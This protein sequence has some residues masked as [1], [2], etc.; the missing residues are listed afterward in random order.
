MFQ[1]LLNLLLMHS[2]MIRKNKKF[3]LLIN[4]KIKSKIISNNQVFKKKRKKK[5]C[6]QQIKLIYLI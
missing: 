2:L 4:L 6:T 5:L 1:V 3:V